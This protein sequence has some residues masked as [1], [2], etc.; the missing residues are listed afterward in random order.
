MSNAAA[1]PITAFLLPPPDS[2]SVV[3]PPNVKDGADPTYAEGWP[4]G[5]SAGFSKR[6]SAACAGF[7]SIFDG[8]GSRAGAGA[9]AA[10][11]VIGALGVLKTGGLNSIVGGAGGATLG[12]AGVATAALYKAGG[13]IGAGGFSGAGAAGISFSATGA[14]FAAAAAAG[15]AAG[16][17]GAAGF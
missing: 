15:H 13:A 11:L 6:S 16:G 8:A 5:A 17:A 10:P 3:A 9:L 7:C 14:G 12:V 2:P 1:I 4:A